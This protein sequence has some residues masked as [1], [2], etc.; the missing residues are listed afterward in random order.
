MTK[1]EAIA[2]IHQGKLVE[3]SATE[4]NSIRTAIQDQAGKWIEQGQDMRAMIALEEVKRLDQ[5]HG[6]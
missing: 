1:D 3:C 5:K 2:A 4:Y 6:L